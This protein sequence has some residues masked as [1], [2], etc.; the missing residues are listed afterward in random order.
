MATC[1][2]NGAPAQRGMRD[3]AVDLS[4]ISQDTVCHWRHCKTLKH[5]VYRRGLTIWALH[6]VPVF[7]SVCWPVSHWG[8]KREM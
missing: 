2:A 3:S 6:G 8:S 7:P 4:D 5:H 1:L